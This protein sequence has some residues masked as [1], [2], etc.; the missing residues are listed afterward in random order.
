[1]LL[2]DR[3]EVPAPGAPRERTPSPRIPDIMSSPLR[4]VY[5][6]LLSAGGEMELDGELC[7][8]EDEVPIC[9]VYGRL[10]KIPEIGR[11]SEIVFSAVVGV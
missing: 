7:A 10:R 1:M 11:A 9:D 8:R 5:A 6:V 3:A 4:L 2:P